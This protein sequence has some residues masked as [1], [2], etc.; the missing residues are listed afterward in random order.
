MFTRFCGRLCKCF[1]AAI[2]I[3]DTGPFRFSEYNWSADSWCSLLGY[4]LSHSRL[5]SRVGLLNQRPKGIKRTAVA[6]AAVERHAAKLGSTYSSTSVRFCRSFLFFFL[7]RL[8][9]GNSTHRPMPVRLGPRRLQRPAKVH[10]GC[11]RLRNESGE[12]GDE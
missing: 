8:Y 5:L 12:S 4:R 10:V 9:R 1:V 6:D 3:A 11:G 7:G 2:Q